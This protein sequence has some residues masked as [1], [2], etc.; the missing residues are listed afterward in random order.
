MQLCPIYM[1]R[2]NTRELS[3]TKLLKNENR[4][5][6]VDDPNENENERLRLIDSFAHE[7]N[8]EKRERVGKEIEMLGQFQ[9]S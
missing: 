4:R 2:L 3:A 7:K 5:K 9:K 6:I 8:R 1:S